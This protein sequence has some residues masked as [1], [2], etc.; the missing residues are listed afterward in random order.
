M[1]LFSVDG[2]RHGNKGEREGEGSILN[3]LTD[4]LAEIGEREYNQQKT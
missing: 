2:G 4:I 1:P 3:E